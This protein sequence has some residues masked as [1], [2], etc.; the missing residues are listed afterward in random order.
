MKDSRRKPG[1]A[2]ACVSPSPRCGMTLLEVL[3]AAIILA[4]AIIPIY[5][6]MVSTSEAELETAKIAMAKDI[7]TSVRQ[8][9]MARPFSEISNQL[10]GVAVGVSAEVAPLPV[11][12]E[13]IIEVQ[14]KYGKREF[15]LSLQGKKKSAKVIQIDATVAFAGRGNNMRSE[16]LS[17]MAVSEK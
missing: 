13:K 10:D 8:E 14:K 12:A 16:V 3:V 2:W 11:T 1:E 7:L 17:F 6:S 5:R 15:L 9:F 4:V